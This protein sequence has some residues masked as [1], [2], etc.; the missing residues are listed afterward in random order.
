MQNELI[1]D[2][3]AKLIVENKREVVDILRN[4]TV[5]VSIRDSDGKIARLLTKHIASDPK[6]RYDITDL[7]KQKAV[8]M[9]HLQKFM[10]NLDTKKISRKDQKGKV[11]NKTVRKASSFGNRIRGVVSD[12]NQ[13]ESISNAI[14]KSLENTFGDKN[15][16]ADGTPFN[17][18]VK[19]LEQRI[20]LNKMQNAD[21]ENKWSKKTK[22]IVAGVAALLVIVGAVLYFKNKGVSS[23]GIIP[24]APPTPTV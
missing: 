12:E 8:N 14:A 9:E 6:V 1:V 10:N 15:F 21:G 22:I 20:E 18:N 16:A 5:N 2:E 3:I 24:P 17:P 7:I 11:Q 4:N 23:P 13:H 19:I